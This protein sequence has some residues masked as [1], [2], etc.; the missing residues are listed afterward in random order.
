L[1]GFDA[2]RALRIAFWFVPEQV[3]NRIPAGGWLTFEGNENWS[4]ER[5]VLPPP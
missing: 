5:Q 2:W 3:A 1:Y 4:A